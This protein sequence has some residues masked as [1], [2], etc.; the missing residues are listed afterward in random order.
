M[1]SVFFEKQGLFIF[2][3]K[4]FK[5]RIYLYLILLV[6]PLLIGCDF[7]Y[8]IIQKQAAHEKA[9]IGEIVPFVQNEKVEEIQKLLKV[10]GCSPG[11]IDG[12]MGQKVRE[13]IA[14]FQEDRG[15]DVNRYIDKPT[16]EELNLYTDLGLVFDGEID[17]AFIQQILTREGFDPGKIDGKLGSKTIEAIK[18]FQDQN[19]LKPDGRIGPNT[20]SIFVDY[21]MTSEY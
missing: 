11:K 16:W 14:S 12:K 18:R 21:I 10:N 6:L 19:G 4:M 1:T 3:S 13:A 15:L 5:M 20:L 2:R 9:L 8:G 17:I 7:I